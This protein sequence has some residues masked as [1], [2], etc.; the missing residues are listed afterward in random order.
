MG[1]LARESSDLIA[2]FGNPFGIGLQPLTMMEKHA[3][4][5]NQLLPDDSLFGI[6]TGLLVLGFWLAVC[7]ARNRAYDLLGEEKGGSVAQRLPMLA[8]IAAIA[9]MNLWLM[10]QD[11]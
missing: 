4:M 8:F 2:A 7:I 6:Q 11:M 9:A 3:R 5:M 10:A 1:H